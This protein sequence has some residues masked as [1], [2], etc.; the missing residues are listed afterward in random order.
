[1]KQY[2]GTLFLGSPIDEIIL[3]EENI[4]SRIFLLRSER[5]MLDSD[6]AEIY[7][8][9]TRMLNCAVKRN[10]KRFPSDFMFQ[11][12]I[13]EWE[14]LKYQ[15]GTSSWGGKRKLPYVFTEHGAIML[16]AVLNGQRAIDASIS[17][18]RA[19]LKLRQ[20]ITMSKET[21]RKLEDF[22]GKTN[23]KLSEHD[24]MFQ[25]VFDTLK[26][27]LIQESKPK[28]SIGLIKDQN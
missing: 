28:N 27:V 11:L 4:V 3:N 13:E 7:K 16:A 24:K 21:A 6:L 10:E 22:E 25:L 2:I 9:E 5:V 23:E 15:Y 12:S 17:V 1:M 19:F 14:N 26:K 20:L 18:V 8:V